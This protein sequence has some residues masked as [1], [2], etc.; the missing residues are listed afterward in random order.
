MK[1]TIGSV[2]Q[3][4]LV[5]AGFSGRVD[6]I[7]MAILDYICDLQ[8]DPRSVFVDNV[9][10][11]S[12]NKLRKQLPLLNLVDNLAVGARIKK[13]QA[14]GFLDTYLYFDGF[15]SDGDDLYFYVKTTTLYFDV[16][17]FDGVTLPGGGL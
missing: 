6:I 7:D 1:H 14:V 2:N 17:R 12:C 9:L 3:F 13:M 8:Q 4:T 5:K 10:F 11:L 16:C 15:A